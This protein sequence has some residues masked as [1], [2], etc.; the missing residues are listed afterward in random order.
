[1][2]EHRAPPPPVRVDSISGL[3]TKPLP[4]LPDDESNK[5]KKTNSKGKIRDEFLFHENIFFFS[6][7]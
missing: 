5:K 1:M 4:R 2:N 7:P 6:S 3:E